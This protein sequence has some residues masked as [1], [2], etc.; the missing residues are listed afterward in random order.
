MKEAIQ[1]IREL[2][3]VEHP[4][5]AERGLMR[6]ALGLDE[7]T[8]AGKPYRNYYCTRRDNEVC[9]ALEAKG[10]L[11]WTDDTW[12]MYRGMWAVTPA[13][14]DALKADPA[15]N[16]AGKATTVKIADWSLYPCG[17][18]RQHGDHSAEAYRDD[19]LIPAL[20]K[21]EYVEVDMSGPL[22][23]G[24]S[25]L[26]ECFGGLARAGY[27][28]NELRERMEITNAVGSDHALIWEFIEE[29]EHAG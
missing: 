16:P 17:R 9:V 8:G 7:E 15:W 4:T 13:G 2:K 22:A 11:K 24:S 5:D 12:T 27:T 18:Y 19:H 3:P 23:F 1:K 14:L 10:W 21:H 6:H 29:A 26:E 28:T 20:E 25:W